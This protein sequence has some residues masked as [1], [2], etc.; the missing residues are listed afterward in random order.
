[1]M[2]NGPLLCVRKTLANPNP[3][4]LGKLPNYI[5][6]SFPFFLFFKYHAALNI[7]SQ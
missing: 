3:T 5:I 2:R 6:N 1:M 4:G 7:A